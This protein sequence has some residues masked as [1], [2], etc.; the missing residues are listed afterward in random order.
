MR[1]QES[2]LLDS[3]AFVSQAPVQ[4]RLPYCQC[5]YFLSSTDSW[6][7][8]RQNLV[9]MASHLRFMKSVFHNQIASLSN[10]ITSILD[11][12]LMMKELY[13]STLEVHVLLKGPR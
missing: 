1:S 10:L 2:N 6:A 3:H 13:G 5:S 9:L 7:D 8:A 4:G 11:V 12:S